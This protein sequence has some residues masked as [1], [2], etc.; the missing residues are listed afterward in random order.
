[1]WKSQKPKNV[2]V[3]WHFWLSILIRTFLSHPMNSLSNIPKLDV[4]RFLVF[5]LFCSYTDYLL[6]V[7]F[8]LRGLQNMYVWWNSISYFWVKHIILPLTFSYKVR[9]GKKMPVVKEKYLLQYY[10]TTYISIVASCL[11]FNTIHIVSES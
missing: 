6:N 8:G 10:H 4:L 9:K 7:I 11:S 3:K 5:Q 1:M 2:R